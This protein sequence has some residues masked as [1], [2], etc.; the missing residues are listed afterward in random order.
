[1]LR[2]RIRFCQVKL[3]G[4]F[5]KKLRGFLCQ[6]WKT[7]ARPS[8][9]YIFTVLVYRSYRLCAALTETVAINGETDHHKVNPT[10]DKFVAVSHAT[11]RNGKRYTSSDRQVVCSVIGECQVTKG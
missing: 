3:L 4:S 7:K 9:S 2:Y 6:C 10:L 11:R 1:M 8:I 5:Q